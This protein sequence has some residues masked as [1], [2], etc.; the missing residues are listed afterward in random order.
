MHRR[1]R[2]DVELT[3]DKEEEKTAKEGRGFF[4]HALT[5][6]EFVHAEVKIEDRTEAW[7]TG[8][9]T[10]EVEV[11][12]TAAARRVRKAA[13][14]SIVLTAPDEEDYELFPSRTNS[15]VSTTSAASIASCGSTQ[16]QSTLSLPSR[17]PPASRSSSRSSVSSKLT[18]QS[19]NSFQPLTSQ[20]PSSIGSILEEPILEDDMVEQCLYDYSW[21]E[22]SVDCVTQFSPKSAGTKGEGSMSSVVVIPTENQNDNINLFKRS[23]P[24][25]AY[26][27]V[28]MDKRPRTMSFP[29]VLNQPTRKSSLAWEQLK[30]LTKAEGIVPVEE[31]PESM[32]G[33]RVLSMWVKWHQCV[34][35]PKHIMYTVTLG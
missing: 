2:L 16:V 13:M 18:V 28:H 32:V 22:E 30:L 4:G 17:S 20:P 8:A 19:T 23:E 35:F 27:E 9:L 33:I 15:L 31:A 25:R 21:G 12:P 1:Y 3:G 11:P 26:R 10:V 5:S 14:P 34:M 24:A 6:S 7:H 29:E